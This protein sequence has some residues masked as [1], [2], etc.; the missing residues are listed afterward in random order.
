MGAK[1]ETFWFTSLYNFLK[2]FKIKNIQKFGLRHVRDHIGSTKNTIVLQCIILCQNVWYYC[3]TFL[4]VAEDSFK[5][6]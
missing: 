2:K 4:L 5:L 6:Q 1:G 3:G